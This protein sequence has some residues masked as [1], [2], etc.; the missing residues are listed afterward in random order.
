MLAR[1]LW[2]ARVEDITELENNPQ[3]Q[4]MHAIAEY[5]H[6][7]AGTVRCVAPSITMS[8]TPAQIEMAPPLV[9]EH[10]RQILEEFH[11][12]QDVID[13]LFS[14]GAISEEH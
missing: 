4:H 1:D 12:D 7:Q 11:V 10:T 2:V 5:E 3:V 14:E 8:E 9:G 6:G 13:R